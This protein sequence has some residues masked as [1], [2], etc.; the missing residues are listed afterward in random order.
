MNQVVC[1]RPTATPSAFA[2]LKELWHAD[3]KQLQAEEITGKGTKKP[4]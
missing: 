2:R 3:K 4:Q 1:P